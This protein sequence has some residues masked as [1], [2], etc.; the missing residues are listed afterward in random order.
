[1]INTLNLFTRLLRPSKPLSLLSYSALTNQSFF[2]FSNQEEP[3]A[4][5]GTEPNQ[6]EEDRAASFYRNTIRRV[7]TNEKGRGKFTEHHLLR[8]EQLVEKSEQEPLLF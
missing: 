1:M 4:E 3:K 6:P 8:L 7:N 2:R 5:E